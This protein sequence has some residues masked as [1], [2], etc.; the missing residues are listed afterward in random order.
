MIKKTISKRILSL[1]VTMAMMISLFPTMTIS[2]SADIS[3]S[4]YSFNES[5]GLL[6]IHNNDG[7]DAWDAELP[8]AANR[9]AVKSVVIDNGVTT[10]KG[11]AFNN[12]TSLSSVTIPSTVA[13]IYPYAFA[14]CTSLTSVTFQGNPPSFN[15]SDQF[16]NCATSGTITVPSGK[17]SAYE[18]TLANKGLT[19][20]A[21][22]WV[23]T[24]SSAGSSKTLSSTES[25][26]LT[27]AAKYPSGT[28]A[29]TGG[30]TAT[31]DGTTLTLNNIVFSTSHQ[32]AI[33]LPEDAKI[34]LVDGTTNSIT[35]TSICISGSSGIYALENLTIDGGTGTLTAT[36]G[37]GVMGSYG[38]CG[39]NIVVNSGTINAVGGSSEE[40][41]CGIIAAN[42]FLVTGGKV[43][44][45][46]DSYAIMPPYSIAD[47]TTKGTISGATSGL[48]TAEYDSLEN[49][50]CINGEPA[51]YLEITAS[52]SS[53][54]LSSITVT[55]APTKTTYTAGE[56]F[57]STGMVVTATYSDDSNAPVTNYTVSPSGALTISDTSVTISYTEGSE[58]KTT[59]HAIT[60]NATATYS[61][62]GT[63]YDIDTD[64]PISGVTV[65]MKQ[66][67]VNVGSPVITGPDGKYELTGIPAG[68][69]Y[70][71]YASKT[72]YDKENSSSINLSQNVTDC[73]IELQ[74]GELSSIAV[75]TPPTKTTYDV[76]DTF[77][78]TG[79]VITA[80]FDYGDDGEV[81]DYTFTPSGAL[82]LSDTTI[83]IS[84]TFNGDTETTTQAIT[85][86]SSGAT[87]LSNTATADFTSLSA[88]TYAGTS[89]TATWDGTTLTLDN[90]VFSTSAAPA[91]KLPANATIELVGINSVTTTKIA[92]NIGDPV[93]GIS[94]NGN[95][96]IKG[97]GSLTST[98][99]QTTGVSIGIFVNGSLTIDGGTINSIGRNCSTS[100]GLQ[101]NS[102]LTVNSGSLNAT[103]GTTTY[104]SFGVNM[105]SN[106]GVLTMN[107]GTIT[108][109]SSTSGGS[110]RVA[111]LVQVEPTNV[112]ATDS[113]SNTIY[114]TSGGYVTASGGSTYSTSAI[115]TSNIVFKAVTDI[116]EVPTTATAGTD[117]TLSG[118][119]A[120]ADATN[121]TIA[122]SIKDAG[123]TGATLAGSVLSTT[124]SGTVTV[125]A[126]ITNG[127]ATSTNY[128]KD[129][130]ITVSNAHKA[131]TGITEVPTTATA[132]TDLTLSGTVTPADATNKTIAW[133]IKDAGTTGATL[134]G[135][136]L[137]TTAS[138][139]VTVTATITNGATSSSNYTKDFTITVSN[140]HKAVTDITGVPTTATAG[141]DLTLT[142]T[143]T[144]IDATN[145][146][147]VWT[148]KTVGT[149]GATISGSRL[150]TTGAGTVTVTATITNGATSS[151]N[152]TKDFTITVSDNTPPTPTYTLTV[153][154]GI[155][156]SATSGGTYAAGASVSI[157]ATANSGYTFNGWTSSNGGTFGNANNASTTFTMPSGNTT[158]IANFT[159]TGGGN[160]N[161][162]PRPVY[163]YYPPS[164]I[165]P[166]T[167][168]KTED[169]NSLVT[170]STTNSVSKKLEKAKD[171]DTVKTKIGDDNAVGKTVLNAFKGKN[172]DLVIT[173]KNNAEITINGNDIKKAYSSTS[174]LLTYNT[175]HIPTSLV[176]KAKSKNKGSSTAQFTFGDE[177]SFGFT[178]SLTVKFKDKN[179]GKTVT[180]YRYDSANNKLV[181]VST[182]VIG[183]NGKTTFEGISK[184]GDFVTVIK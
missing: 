156:G 5:M 88:G 22:N 184:G 150:S 182:S 54:T 12:C 74:A 122:W 104:N 151:T 55:Q 120:P 168:T 91:L 115:L 134:A 79:M 170:G 27:N 28:Y 71:A 136:V 43:T 117:L 46:G 103:S 36:G 9:T 121:K 45:K 135:S 129:F 77:D 69:S 30:G 119:V 44:C 41:S 167:P 125:T 23:I 169:S 90:F 33:T 137:S 145:K 31:W 146:T 138:G 108:A 48:V 126:T 154:A 114:W 111:M 99:G 155:G 140:A 72:G 173:T 162:N 53:K 123:T 3:N 153:N 82:S 61:V 175:K 66:A 73:D 10:I 78:S 148:V 56:S 62:S 159:Y 128:T 51:K 29:G 63:I 95:L 35:S 42:D 142:G 106:T 101:V 177:T 152:Y 144:P 84:Y 65:Q 7:L 133:S 116:T 174:L 14:N 107:G 180:L 166:T 171:G 183:K 70:A 157:S 85:I 4:Y 64:E 34:V 179:V 158:I 181:L 161:P 164:N 110:F 11:S 39:A 24:E 113:S 130:T 2:V 58:T 178:C 8:L 15:G 160:V 93:Y 20:G 83:T 75:T 97:P 81:T 109:Q 37:Y 25:F 80:Y 124:A 52:T 21:S 32:N 19:F 59:T 6:T 16:Q 176:D 38:I 132:G 18:T 149:T 87:P 105:G 141:T 96:T 127:A 67:N 102:N 89:G 131:V 17:V 112:T 76:G 60:V 98:G 50:Y 94:T 47:V 92:S 147:I 40:E 165:T 26:D 86:N 13:F 172:V 68:S 163:P 143:V 1:L 49:T 118:T 139:T 57:D 100:Y